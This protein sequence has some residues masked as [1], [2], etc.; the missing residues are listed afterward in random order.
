M[1]FTPTAIDDAWI[2]ECKM[3]TDPRGF[4]ARAFCAEEF[5]QHGLEANFVQANLSGNKLKHTVRG[6]HMQAEPF[7]EVKL[8]R[9]TRGVIFDAFI[10]MRPDSPTFLQWFGTELTQDN[11]RMLYV[12]KG[13]AHG[14]Q[15]LCDDAEVFYLVSTPYQPASERGVRWNDPKIGIQWPEPARAIISDKD[16]AWPLL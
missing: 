13:C 16:N 15:S 11:H 1:I 14:Y 8:V 5:E 4:F 9:C 3:L 12:P 2:I 7:G 6:M 10:D